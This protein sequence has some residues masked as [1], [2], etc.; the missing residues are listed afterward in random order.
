MRAE[1]SERYLN[2]DDRE[3]G[4]ACALCASSLVVSDLV[5]ITKRKFLPRDYKKTQETLK[6]T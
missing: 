5:L 1:E 3:R 4:L 2:N 6:K